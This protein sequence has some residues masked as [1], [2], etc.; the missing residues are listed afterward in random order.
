MWITFCKYIWNVQKYDRIFVRQ[1]QLKMTQEFKS[2][3]QKVAE[4]ADAKTAFN[5]VSRGFSEDFKNGRFTAYHEI[6]ETVLEF[7]RDCSS[8][9]CADI[10]KKA[11]QYG[12][13]SEKQAW[14]V[15]FEFIK[16]KHQ[17]EAWVESQSSKFD[18]Q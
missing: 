13:P 9:F 11:L 5:T 2:T 1:K 12:N 4:I 15:A 16:I 3:Y 14:C 10:A 8:T 18:N 6:G 17:Y 7:V